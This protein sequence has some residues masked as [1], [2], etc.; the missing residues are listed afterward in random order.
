MSQT[1][2]WFFALVVLFFGQIA[3]AQDAKDQAPDF[4]LPSL[5]S[6]QANI[7]LSNSHGKLI[8][9]DFWA[10][11]CGPCKQSFPWMNAMQEKYQSQ[12]LEIIAVNLD[13]NSDD[14]KKFL[15]SNQA[16][17]IVALDNKG[18]TPRN[19]H[20]KGMPTSFLIG[21]DG[22][23]LMQHMGFNEADRE[24]LERVIKSTLEDKK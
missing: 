23:I 15:A 20:V 16:K 24:K 17:F 14:A 13:G 7:K 9:L 11:W 18:L 10:S 3:L 6:K 5:D 12:G 2:R 21:R 22:K 4:D 8:Y 19:Y 1:S